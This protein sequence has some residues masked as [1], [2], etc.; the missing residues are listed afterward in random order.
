MI[1]P[2]ATIVGMGITHNTTLDNLVTDHVQHENI[3]ILTINDPIIVRYSTCKLAHK[4]F[5]I[6]I[7]EDIYMYMYVQSDKIEDHVTII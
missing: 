1:L 4:I 5:P 3:P 7:I 2:A 6:A